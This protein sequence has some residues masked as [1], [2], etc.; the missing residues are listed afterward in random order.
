MRPPVGPLGLELIADALDRRQIPCRVLDLAFERRPRAALDQALALRPPIVAFSVRNLDD[1]YYASQKFL[2][3]PFRAYA[4]SARAAGAI[5]VVGGVGFSVAPTAAL[6][7]L[8]ADYGLRGDGEESLPL[9][10]LRLAAGANLDGVPGLV[11][12]G[13]P[14]PAPALAD[15]SSPEPSTRRWFDWER[16][17]RMGGQAGIETRRGCDRGCIYCAEAVAK[18][19]ALRRRPA[20]AVAEEVESLVRRGIHTLHLCDPEWNLS[21]EHAEAVC[22]ALL[23]RGLG[24]KLRFYA[25][26][27]PAP[28]DRELARLM[29]RAGCVGIDFGADAADDGML[30]R[31]GRDYDAG[32]LETAADA[33]RAAG[34]VFM[35]DLLLGGPG[36]TRASLKRTIS[37]MKKIKPDRVGVSFGVRL[38]AG[39][40]LERLVREAGPLGENPSLHGAVGRNP[41]LIRPVFFVEA[42]LGP[43]PEKYLH[44]L[45]GEDRRFLFASREDL[46]RNYNYNNNAPLCREIR[47]GARGAFWDILRRMEG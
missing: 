26:A 44:G 28:M 39:T 20:E 9:L 13:G 12:P 4:R 11:T 14:D 29:A 41:G 10:A 2:L 34:I 6:S 38:F 46:R 19:R 17:F 40:R 45:I 21:R 22:R 3:P 47:R 5:T 42:G 16:Y 23:R 7:Y 35:F 33:C 30:A 1:C 18:G 8:G 15:L 37:R 36:E 43:A 25:Y 27:L 32:A 31:L 24:A